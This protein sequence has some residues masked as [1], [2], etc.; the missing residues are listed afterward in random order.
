MYVIVNSQRFIWA[1]QDISKDDVKQTTS[2]IDV[3]DANDDPQHKRAP[4]GPM[5]MLSSC[6]NA[7][8]VI[9]GS[10]P[11]WVAGRGLGERIEKRDWNC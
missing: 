4:F 5:Y 10:W 8:D 6:D 11:G 3:R 7:K 2:T 1:E 9:Y